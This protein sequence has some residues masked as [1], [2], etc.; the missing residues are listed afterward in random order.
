MA[1]F[2]HDSIRFCRIP[3]LVSRAVEDLSY[4]AAWHTY[5]QLMEADALA[6]ERAKGLLVKLK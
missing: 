6:R 1:A 2:L 5:A 4:T 3:E